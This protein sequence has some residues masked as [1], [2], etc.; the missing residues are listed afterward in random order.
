M[1][2]EKP[3]SLATKSSIR[4][5]SNELIDDGF[6]FSSDVQWSRTK[7]C[8]ITWIRRESNSL[9]VAD[10]MAK[11]ASLDH[12]EISIVEHIPEPL[13]RLATLD[14]NSLFSSPVHVI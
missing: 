7:A 11:L 6:M 2:A 4:N 12:L 5:K 10:G 1:D 8:E 14:K 13:V 3:A 9:A